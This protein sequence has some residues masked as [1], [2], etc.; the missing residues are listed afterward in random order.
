MAAC[1]FN[2]CFTFVMSGWEGSAHD[3]RIFNFATS[4]PRYEFPNPPQGKYY[5]VDSGYPLQRG[6]LKPYQDTRYHLPDFARGGRRAEGR[7]EIFNHAHSSLRSV[8]ER[9]FG[10][11]KKKWAILRDMP[12]YRFDKQ[13]AI[14]IAT[15][16]LHNFIRRHP[17]RVDID[18]SEYEQR[19]RD[20]C[21][22]SQSRQQTCTDT[23]GGVE[24]MITLRNTIADQLCEARS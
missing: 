6:Y 12:S 7:Q 21:M 11:W 2:M 5:L 15:M 16:C 14:V 3:S 22:T 4:D 1:D 18:F 17:S 23:A 24:E 19:D 8:I 13:I 10:V 9:S 20:Q